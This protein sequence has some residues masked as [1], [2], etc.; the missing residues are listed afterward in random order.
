[1]KTSRPQRD[2]LDSIM[3]SLARAIASFDSSAKRES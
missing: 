2:P 1:L 3:D